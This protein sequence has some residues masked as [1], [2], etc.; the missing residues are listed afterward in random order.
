[1]K[2]REQEHPGP[3]FEN[4]SKNSRQP[5]WRS[6]SCVPIPDVLK[7]DNDWEIITSCEQL[8]E[9]GCSVNVPRQICHGEWNIWG[10]L[11]RS[12]CTHE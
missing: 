9:T 8:T 4:I 5:D 6:A 10:G 3:P 7:I 11:W 1:M 12:A 2:H